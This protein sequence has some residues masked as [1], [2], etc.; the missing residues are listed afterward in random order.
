M[1]AEV[2]SLFQPN[3]MTTQGLRRLVVKN[4][5]LDLVDESSPGDIPRIADLARFQS[6]PAR[7]EDFEY[8]EDRDE[9]PA[10]QPPAVPELYRYVTLDINEPEEHWKA[11]LAEDPE[12]A[13]S[14]KEPAPAPEAAQTPQ[15]TY[16]QIDDG[17]RWGVLPSSQLPGYTMPQGVVVPVMVPAGFVAFP[18]DPFSRWPANVQPTAYV[19]TTPSG[20]EA[21]GPPATSGSS[22]LPL[23]PAPPK[24]PPIQRFVSVMSGIC[25]FHWTVNASLLTTSDRE[26]V[27]P[28]FELSFHGVNVEFK[29]IIRPVPSN[30]SRGGHAFRKAQGMGTVELRCLAEDTSL[31]PTVTFRVAVGSGGS[32]A[33]TKHSCTAP[34]KHNFGDRATCTLP[35]AF[36]FGKAAA[37]DQD[38]KAKTFVIV[39]EILTGEG[40]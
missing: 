33:R 1:E 5:F 13:P 39:L 11:L 10:V 7:V 22:A 2:D 8:S 31:N 40:A 24:A 18:I 28:P 38:T 34:V 35:G 12:L 23:C 19:E 32:G 30:A 37:E 15:P 16:G 6:A 4:T 25:R 20:Q 9:E 36:N 29:M 17:M 26:K 3:T 14:Q 21:E 27:S